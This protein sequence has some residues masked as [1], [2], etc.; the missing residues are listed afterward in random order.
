[1][2]SIAF[3]VASGYDT[4]AIAAGGL[5]IVQARA[6]QRGPAVTGASGITIG[7]RYA[8]LVAHDT[9]STLI[10]R[11]DADRLATPRRIPGSASERMAARP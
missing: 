6:L 11:A 10:D 7:V 8:Q 5:P 2:D 4:R 9:P 1:M 3:V